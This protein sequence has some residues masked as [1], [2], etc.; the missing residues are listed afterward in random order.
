MPRNCTLTHEKKISKK[1]KSKLLNYANRKLKST[2]KL[3]AFKLGKYVCARTD[4]DKAEAL[5]HFFKSVFT[6]ETPGDCAVVENQEKQISGE[7]HLTEK[8]IFKE[9]SKID[10]K[11]QRDQIICTHGFSMKL[12]MK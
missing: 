6:I 11:N 3:P 5:S 8:I 10:I 7:I 9:L 2:E 12:E 4:K 1:V